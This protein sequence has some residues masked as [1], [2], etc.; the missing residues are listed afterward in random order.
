MTGQGL[1]GY[2]D[3][4][5]HKSDLPCTVRVSY[6]KSMEIIFSSCPKP[7]DQKACPYYRRR[8]AGPRPGKSVGVQPV[9]SV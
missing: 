2:F 3:C 8:A 1:T 7:V 5:G 6:A 9:L 4:L